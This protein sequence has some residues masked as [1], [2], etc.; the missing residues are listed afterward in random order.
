M[1]E[2]SYENFIQEEHKVDEIK[3]R[4]NEFKKY[5]EDIIKN[6]ND[7]PRGILQVNGVKIK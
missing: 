1:G 2:W 7:V 4:I 5:Q 6:I 3:F